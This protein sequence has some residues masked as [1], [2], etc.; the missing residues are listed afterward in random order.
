[1]KELDIILPRV[2]KE[3]KKEKCVPMNNIE[4]SFYEGVELMNDSLAVRVN[5]K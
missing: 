4:Y 2:S 5:N 3:D 1:M